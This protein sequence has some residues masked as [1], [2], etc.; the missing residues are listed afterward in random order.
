MNL[1]EMFKKKK[2]VNIDSLKWQLNEAAKIIAFEDMQSL[3]ALQSSFSQN[4]RMID[5]ISRLAWLVDGRL[6][7]RE[8][9]IK[10]PAVANILL[11][12]LATY[13]PHSKLTELARKFMSV[14]E[15]NFNIDQQLHAVD[16]ILV[17][18]NVLSPN[19]E[20]SVELL[21]RLEVTRQ[22]YQNNPELKVI[23]SGGGIAK[24][25]TE[26]EVMRHWLMAHGVAAEDIIVEDKSRDTV[27]SIILSMDIWEKHSTKGICLVTSSSHMERSFVLLSEYC[28]RKDFA[29]NLACQIFENPNAS[30]SLTDYHLERFLLFKDLGRILGIWDYQTYKIP[31]VH[32]S[33]EHK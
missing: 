25:I 15:A 9:W 32:R 12:D 8:T 28:K 18:A 13:L 22:L 20:P 33:Y 19:A 17:L 27:E 3:R 7:Q 5:P 2:P 30:H 21:G 24:G 6:L 4:D 26:A 11:S 14:T 23:V 1:L 29:V 16:F 10:T 31:P